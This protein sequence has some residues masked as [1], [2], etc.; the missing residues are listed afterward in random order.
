[1]HININ[2]WQA[3]SLSVHGYSA[4]RRT[5]VGLGFN[6][7]ELKRTCLHFDILV[8]THF[9]RVNMFARK[10]NIKLSIELNMSYLYYLKLV[11]E[12]YLASRTKLSYLYLVELYLA[13]RTKLSAIFIPSFEL[14]S[15]KIALNKIINFN[16]AI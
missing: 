3:H 4:L 12:L 2:F 8:A 9:P 1:M 14:V 15:K 6:F 10:W 11:E 16:D 13:S 7:S 5:A